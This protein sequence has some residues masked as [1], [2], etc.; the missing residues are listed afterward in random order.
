MALAAVCNG[1]AILGKLQR[2][3]Q[4]VGLADRGLHGLA[5]RPRFAG[6]LFMVFRVCH[7]AGGF[8]QLNAGALAEA[9]FGRVFIELIYAEVMSCRIEE[10]IAGVLDSAG[11]VQIAVS[12]LLIVLRIYPAVWRKS[13]L[14]IA[15]ILASTFNRRSGVY[16][17][18][19]QRGY[20]RAGLEGRAGRIAALKRAVIKRS[21]FIRKQLIVFFQQLGRIVGRPVCN[22]KRLA[23]FYIYN[24]HGGT[25]DNILLF[26][27]CSAGYLLLFL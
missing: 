11:D 5:Y 4:A 16:Y 1:C 27:I 21:V 7:V 24:D 23:C 12:Q 6:K 26:L 22:G 19:G 8:G 18:L 25:V 10:D 17:S 15:R 9:E 13:V 20:R 2:R 14:S 3:E